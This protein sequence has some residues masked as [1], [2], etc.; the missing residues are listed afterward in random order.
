MPRF[1]YQDIVQAVPKI[2]K[3]FLQTPQ[4]D[5][6]PLSKLLD[7]RVILKLETLNPIRSFKGRGSELLTSNS[8]EKELICP[9]AGNFGQAMALSCRKRGIYLTVYASVHANELK[10][11]RM[12]ELGAK[13]IQ[14][15]EDFDD[16]KEIACEAAGKNN[17]RFVEDAV[18]VETVIGAGT[19]GLELAS[20][21]SLID[22]VMVPLGNG[23]LINGI[24]TVFEKL[25][26]K[27]TMA[28]AQSANAPAMIESWKSGKVIVHEKIDTIADGIGV[29]VPIPLALDDMRSL[30]HRGYLAYEETIVRAMKLLQVHAGLLVEP[31]AAVGLAAMLENPDLFTNKT[32][33][34]VLTGSNL[35]EQQIQ[36]WF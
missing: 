11:S 5:C 19:I 24:A 36:K 18:D 31:S 32:V 35:M 1:F 3:I 26:P 10:V 22:L 6:E 4:F 2:D 30:V 13:V 20:M 25:S 17:V 21:G 16:A 23:A 9:S 12:K 14:Q 27:T 33:V 7:C 15:G 8:K 28:A 29:R 34:L